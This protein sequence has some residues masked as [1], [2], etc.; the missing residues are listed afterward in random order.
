M[1]GF[2]SYSP[3]S[4]T[5]TCCISNNTTIADY[6]KKT[7]GEYIYCFKMPGVNKDDIKVNTDGNYLKFSAKSIREDINKQFSYEYKIGL[8]KDAD[9]SKQIDAKYNDGLLIVKIPRK[10][11]IV[12]ISIE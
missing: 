4:F 10:N 3:Y 6:C 7:D 8:Q 12:N 2:Y 5:D 1:I 11:N 9:Y